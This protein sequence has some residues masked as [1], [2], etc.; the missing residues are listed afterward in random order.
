MI[1]TA[2]SELR[3][4]NSLG[5][6]LVLKSVYVCGLRLTFYNSVLIAVIIHLS[7]MVVIDEREARR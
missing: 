5:N 4:K 3:R 2:A 6:F 7:S 1:D